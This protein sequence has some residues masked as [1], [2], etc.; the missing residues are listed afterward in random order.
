MT[1]IES[2][3]K[4]YTHEKLIITPFGDYMP[5]ECLAQQNVNSEGK[6]EGLFYH[7]NKIY[8]KADF[9]LF[10]PNP[11]AYPKKRLFISYSS[12]NSAFFQRFLVHLAPLKRMGIVDYWHD[13]MITNGTLWDEKIQ[14]ELES[15]D[16]VVF[17]LSP[18]FLNVPYVLDVEI[19]K[20]IEFKK[21]PFFIQLMDCGWQRFDLLNQYQN[22]SDQKQ[23]N[24]NF[25][26]LKADPND[27]TTWEKI[28]DDLKST[29]ENLTPKKNAL[30]NG[31]DSQRA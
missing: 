27:S 28:I 10:L 9:K 23:T 4:H 25:I 5:A 31:P 18:D 21:H 14:K 15:S 6:D 22:A 29:I 20:A 26:N 19:P 2:Q 17:L 30:T 7:E 11:D 12:Q 3:I 8:R 1:F 16:I 13:R 24:K